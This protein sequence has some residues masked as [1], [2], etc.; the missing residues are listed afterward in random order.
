MPTAYKSKDKATGNLDAGINASTLSILL[1]SGDGANFPQ[2]YSGTATSGGTSST[3][4]STGIGSSGVAVGDHIHNVTDDSWATIE[5]VS[6]NSVT[7]SKLKGGSDNTWQNADVWRVNEFVATIATL[8]A[9]DNDSAYEEVLISGRSTDTLTVATGG[10]GF[11]STTAQSFGAGDSV[12]LRVTSPFVEEIKK[13]IRYINSQVD[14][15]TS[16]ISTNSTDIDNI[17]SGSSFYV[18]AGGSSNAFTA[19]FS[20][21]PAYAA[22]LRLTFKANHTISGSATLNANSLGAKTIKKLDGATDLVSGD[23]VSGQ[24]VEVE[25]D[26]TYLQMLS[27]V[28]QSASTPGAALIKYVSSADSND[29][30]SSTSDTDFDTNYTIDAS[31]IT[32]KFAAGV[33]YKVEAWGVID[34]GA[35]NRQLQLKL[36]FGSTTLI[37]FDA[38][39]PTTAGTL[40]AWHVVC[41]VTC[42]SVGASGTLQASGELRVAA[43]AATNEVLSWKAADSTVTVDTTANAALKFSQ[44]WNVDDGTKHCKIKNIVYSRQATS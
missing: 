19:T 38:L 16:N 17:E 6:S 13:I 36:K 27:P 28:G 7:T 23:I 41:E 29:I 20:P 44:A 2:P 39:Q 30:T 9:D 12:Q 3:L 10:R 24:I 42:R 15:N 33:S 34:G 32:S 37:T 25:Y 1:E 35:S 43:T 21:V 22:G 5:S 11:N 40:R 18:A 8:D 26:G 31:S 14:T 4:N